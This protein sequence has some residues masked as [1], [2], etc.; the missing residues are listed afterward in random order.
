RRESATPVPRSD[1]SV[2][3]NSRCRL[4]L[5]LDAKPASGDVDSFLCLARNWPADLFLLWRESQQIAQWRR[6][7]DNRRSAAALDQ[8]LDLRNGIPPSLRPAVAGLP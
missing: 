8:N 2:V 6:H 3:S 7:R 5:R 4:L 1:E